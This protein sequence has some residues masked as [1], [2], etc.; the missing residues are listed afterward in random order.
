[1]I[2]KTA[3]RSNTV[4]TTT[5]NVEK[6]NGKLGLEIG[7]P[8]ETF[9]TFGAYRALAKLDNV[10]FSSQTVWQTFPDGVYHFD[11][12]K[13]GKVYEMDVVDMP[14]LESESYDVVLSSHQLEHVANPLKALKE[15]SRVVK[16]GG[17]II[18]ILPDKTFC[19][20]HNRDYTLFATVLKKYEANVGEDNLDSLREILTKHDLSMDLAAGNFEQFVRR[21]L[22]NGKNRCM[23]HHVFNDQL[24]DSMC[25]HF[26]LRVVHRFREQL[27]M[28]YIIQK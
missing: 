2:R 8:S 26:H 14:T 16:I 21:S 15:M 3:K 24:V 20:D 13:T 6:L 9:R 22:E 10:V 18:V 11:G 28:W 23:H 4:V 7:G 19:F 1:M 27:N 5:F 17:Y 25:G 12:E